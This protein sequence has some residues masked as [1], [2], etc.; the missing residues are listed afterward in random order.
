[1]A[2]NYYGL[3]LLQTNSSVVESLFAIEAHVRLKYEEEGEKKTANK[4][5]DLCYCNTLR[6]H[7]I[8]VRD[9]RRRYQKVQLTRVNPVPRPCTSI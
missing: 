6:L 5:M 7:S 2:L 8:I 4:T 1:M 3:G 9:T